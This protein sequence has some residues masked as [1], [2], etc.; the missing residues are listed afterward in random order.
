MLAAATESD[1]RKGIN[2]ASWY[3][4]G[5]N[6][7]SLSVVPGKGEASM[8]PRIVQ[9]PKLRGQDQGVNESTRLTFAV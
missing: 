4:A 6:E 1:R 2:I 5:R 7:V 8:R 3:K 9:F